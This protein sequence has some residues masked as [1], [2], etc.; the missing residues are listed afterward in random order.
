MIFGVLVVQVGSQNRSKSTKF[1]VQDGAS[2]HRFSMDFGR[3]LEPSW[4]GKSTQDRSKI[5]PK[6]HQEKMIGKKASWKRLGGVLGSQNPRD[7]IRLAGRGRGGGDAGAT[8]RKDQD[9]IRR[10][11]KDLIRK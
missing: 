10:L 11:G 3:V 6:G 2:W 9:F 1:E 8:P 7:P 5:D 4:E